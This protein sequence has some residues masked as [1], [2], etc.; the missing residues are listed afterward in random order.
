MTIVYMF[1][2]LVGALITS[3][4]LSPYGWLVAPSCA[5]FGGTM[6]ALVLALLVV[7][8]ERGILSSRDLQS[9]LT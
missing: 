8:T 4:V 9:S 5:L 6:L 2:P 7:S 3:M 1:A